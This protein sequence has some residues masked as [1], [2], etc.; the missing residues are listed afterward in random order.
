MRCDAIIRWRLP[1]PAADRGRDLSGRMSRQHHQQARIMTVS[2]QPLSRHRTDLRRLGGKR[3]QRCAR[4][5][6]EH[7]QSRLIRIEHREAAGGRAALDALRKC[8][9]VLPAIDDREAMR[10]VTMIASA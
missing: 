5:M 6:I 2:L 8:L 4:A 9:Q 3:G 10:A 1:M 7:C